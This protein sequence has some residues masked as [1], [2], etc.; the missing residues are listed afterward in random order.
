M[1]EN[2]ENKRRIYNDGYDVSDVDE[3]AYRYIL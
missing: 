2:E 3:V 1:F